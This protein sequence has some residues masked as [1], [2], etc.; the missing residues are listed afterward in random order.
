MDTEREGAVSGSCVG[1]GVRFGSAGCFFYQFFQSNATNI[2]VI[3]VVVSE[4]FGLNT[5]LFFPM[6]TDSN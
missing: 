4:N 2:E 5:F 1:V 6:V 3:Q